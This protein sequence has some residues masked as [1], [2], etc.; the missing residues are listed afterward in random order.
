MLHADFVQID[1]RFSDRETTDR[2]D[3]LLFNEEKNMKK[4]KMITMKMYVHLADYLE[5]GVT[6]FNC[7]MSESGCALL[8]EIEV[9]F[10]MPDKNPVSAKVESLEKSLAKLHAETHIKVTS[11][12]EQIQSL[13]AIGHDI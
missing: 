3:Y 6:L 10:P 4:P 11:M 5:S 1:E 12:K 2:E 13:L 7:D 8:G 9:T